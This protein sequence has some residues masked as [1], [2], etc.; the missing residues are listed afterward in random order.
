M[1]R[2]SGHFLSMSF[3]QMS[4]FSAHGCIIILYDQ[5]KF[6]AIFA[7]ISMIVEHE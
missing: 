7:D 2:K 5:R 1:Y 4:G 3:R 6:Q